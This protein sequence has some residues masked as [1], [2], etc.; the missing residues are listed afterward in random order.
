MNNIGD[1]SLLTGSSADTNE[2]TAAGSRSE[3]FKVAGIEPDDGGEEESVA[4]S[5]PGCAEEGEKTSS[6]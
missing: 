2:A 3:D 5:I 6:D 4:R 1:L